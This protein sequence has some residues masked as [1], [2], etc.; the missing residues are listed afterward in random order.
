MALILFVKK[1]DGSMRVYIDYR[2]LNKVTMKNVSLKV[3]PAKIKAV[4]NWQAPKSVG[5][6][7]T[8]LGLAGYYRRFIQKFSKIASS[9]TKLTKKNTPFMWGEDKEDAFVTLRKKLCEAL[10]LVLPEG[11]KDMIV[12]SDASYFGLG[13]VL[14]Q[15]DKVIAY[16][17]RQSKKHKENYPTHDLEFTG[18]VF[19]W[20]IWR[21]YLYANVV[22]DVLSYKEREKGIRI[23]SL[24]M[25]VTSDLFDRIKAAQ[26][27]ALKEENWKSEHIA[28]YIPH[29]ED[30]GQGITT[31][32]S[33]Y[34]ISF[35]SEV[36]ELQLDEAHK[37]KYSIH[38]GATKM[39]LDLKN[40]Y[41]WPNM[42]K[43]CAKEVAY[44]LELPKE[45]RGIHNTF[46][47][48]Y[49]IKCLANESSVI[50]LD[51]IEIDLGL[52]SREEPVTIL[53]RK[54]R[55]LRNNEAAKFVEDFK[56]LARHKALELEIKRLLR[57]VVSQDI[58]SV[59]QKV[60]VVDTSNLQTE[61]ERMKERF[62][63]CIIKKENEYAK[64]WNDWWLP[65]GRLF[66]LKCK[67]IG[68]SES[69]NLTALMVIQI[70]LWCV[71]SSCSKHMTGN[72]KLLINFVLKFMGTVR[73]GNDHV[74]AILGFGDLQRGNI[75][76]TRVYFVKGLGHNLFSVGQLSIATA[77][78]TQNRSIIHCRFNKTPYELIND[79]KL[80]I[81]FL[82]VFGALCYSKNDH[83]DIGKLGAKGDIGFFIGYSIDSC[84][85]RVY[86]RRTKKI[87]ETMNVSFDELLAM[88]FEQCSSKPGRQSMTSGQISSGLDL[89]F[90]PSNITTQQP[91]KGVLHLLFEAMYDDFIGGQPSAALRT[92][93]AAHAQQVRQ[94]STSSTSIADS[95]PTPTNSSSH[96]TNFPN[97]SQDV[98]ELNSQ[99]QHAQQQGNQAHFQSETVAANVPNAMFDANTF[100]NPFANP[101]TSAAKSSSSQNV[102]PS[103]MH[104][105]YQPHPHEFQ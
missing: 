83:E 8:F 40:Y 68:S 13:C 100:V 64:L 25:I 97:T 87:M 37:S 102:D 58:M 62:E 10:I 1:K 90:A 59:V 103:N 27:E 89:P 91:T 74:A 50:T 67:I 22:A 24:R 39:Y 53:G 101:S 9:L 42:K 88:A 70:C 92:V 32:H 15:R 29:L 28:S 12:Y 65:T 71:D 66:D 51:D 93:P 55:Q 14:M 95:A 96:A 3:D 33:R 61:L 105:F 77:C 31:Q 86:N 80:D 72:L 26:V 46:H 84:A 47:V 36:K 49:L 63:N 48:S 57:V 20:K 78:F 79:R 11:T 34:Y 5:E 41:W 99:Q 43:D 54:S 56:S 35:R 60:S 73:F 30:D 23:H 94:T 7:Q 17:L 4:V 82:H 6:I 38:L 76:I 19:D 75:L 16:A 85:Y 81:S 104:T 2:E 52:I 98:D 45:M 18:V 44:V 69:V 21:R